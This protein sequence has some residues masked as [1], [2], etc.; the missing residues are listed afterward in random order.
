MRGRLQVI[1]WGATGGGTYEWHT[2]RKGRPIRFTIRFIF[3]VSVVYHVFHSTLHCID[4]PL[5]ANLVRTSDAQHTGTP[6]WATRAHSSGC[7]WGGQIG[8]TCHPI[9]WLILLRDD[10][11]EKARRRIIYYPPSPDHQQPSRKWSR[12]SARPVTGTFVAPDGPR[13]PHHR[14]HSREPEPPWSR[15][16][17]GSQGQH[18][19][20]GGRGAS[21]C[22]PVSGRPPTAAGPYA[23]PTHAHRGG[24]VHGFTR[25]CP[26][27][28]GTR[29]PRTC[30][31]PG[32]LASGGPCMMAFEGGSWV[33]YINR[34][35]FS[36]SGSFK[37]T[38]ASG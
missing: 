18:G 29:G 7:L 36:T 20:R 35:C 37:R 14:G 30:P 1:P 9:Q 13:V 25:A 38:Y 23:G 22:G 16:P 6:C 15:P 12:T 21:R 8:Q 11:V 10:D 32:G 19:A 31:W 24:W 17:R 2:W 5:P 33:V 28:A 4:E 26:V 27:S 34:R 3:V